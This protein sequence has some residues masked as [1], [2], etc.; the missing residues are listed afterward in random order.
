[1][2]KKKSKNKAPRPREHE[3]VEKA[4]AAGEFEQSTVV[5]A[6]VSIGLEA[7]RPWY[8]KSSSFWIWV[9]SLLGVSL[10]YMVLKEKAE[11]ILSLHILLPRALGISHVR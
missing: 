1:M 6:T 2:S 9:L 3:P 7:K 11:M 8:V 5:E 4:A 10:F